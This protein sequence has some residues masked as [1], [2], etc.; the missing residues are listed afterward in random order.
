MRVYKKLF[1]SCHS[2]FLNK[3]MHRYYTKHN[4]HEN[5]ASSGIIF[6]RTKVLKEKL[7][8]TFKYINNLLDCISEKINEIDADF[9]EKWSLG[10]TLSFAHKKYRL[11][12]SL[13]TKSTT[14]LT[15]K[16]FQH[17]LKECP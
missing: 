4:M 7:I 8:L 10:K 2:L 11:I 1:L 17:S 16:Y 3:N 9:A 6:F 15:P 5:H 14:I 12:S 13:R